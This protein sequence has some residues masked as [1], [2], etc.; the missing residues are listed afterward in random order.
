MDSMDGLPS[1]EDFVVMGIVDDL[2][3]ELGLDAGDPEVLAERQS[4][5]VTAGVLAVRS[6]EEGLDEEAIRARLMPVI[7]LILEGAASPEGVPASPVEK[8]ANEIMEQVRSMAGINATRIR[9]ALIEAGNRA[10]ARLPED[11]SIQRIRKRASRVMHERLADLLA[12][13]SGAD[14]TEGDVE[15]VS[16][17]TVD[18]NIISDRSTGGGR[19]RRKKLAE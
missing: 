11:A 10:V 1:D 7:R 16:L 14:A 3:V 8:E 9:A 17:D 19:R 6:L 4:E 13:M 12:S 18:E 15:V 5:A 2:I